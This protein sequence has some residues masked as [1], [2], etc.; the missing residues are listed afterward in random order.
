MMIDEYYQTSSV[1][2]SCHE[3]L[4]SS[5]SF[6]VEGSYRTDLAPSNL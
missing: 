4:I 3:L 2:I 1:Q 6:D 5:M